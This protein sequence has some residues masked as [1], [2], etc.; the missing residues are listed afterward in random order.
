MCAVPVLVYF[1]IITR[2]HE[3]GFTKAARLLFLC[4]D[5]LVSHCSSNVIPVLGPSNIIFIL[6]AQWLKGLTICYI[7][8]VC[9]LLRLL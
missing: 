9:K 2:G 6:L 3:S 8:V 4:R 1:K 7:K 5:R